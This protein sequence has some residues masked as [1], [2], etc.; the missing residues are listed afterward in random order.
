MD[1]QNPFGCNRRDFLKV[2]GIGAAALAMPGLIRNASA[3]SVSSIL[4]EVITTDVLI[5]G[6]GLAGTFAA[7]KA[8]K[9]GADVTIADKG[10]VGR[11][12]L[13]PFFGSL[14]YFEESSSVTRQQFIESV[15]QAGKRLVLRDYLEMYMDDSADIAEEF[16]S[17]GVGKDLRGGHGSTYR[18]QIIKNDIRLIERVMITEQKKKY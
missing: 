1:K 5:V 9:S 14:S 18:G 8:K 12:G 6:G 7:L 17:W 3:A 2:A 11:S 15:S 13:S 4:Q 10:T 16:M